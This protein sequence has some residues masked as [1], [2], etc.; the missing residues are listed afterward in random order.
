MLDTYGRK[1]VHSQIEWIAKKLVQLNITPNQVTF[2]ALITGCLT[3][4]L[5][6]WNMPILACGLLWISGLLDAVDGA[7]ARQIKKPTP[8]G[9]VM[10][11]TF[12]RIVEMSVMISLAIKFPYGRLSIL[13]LL[14]SILLSMTVFLTVGALSNQRGLKSFYYQAGIAERTEGFIFLSL[15][16]LF[17]NQLVM[18]SGLF[19]LL[20]FITAM[21]RLVEAY[22]LL[23]KTNT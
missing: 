8:W 2:A 19:A 20:V 1:Y 3:F 13:F 16:I 5:I 4:V 14:C 15:M 22:R 17:S 21:Q 9:T 18:I 23:N 7:M 10:D 11:I 12:D 6:Y